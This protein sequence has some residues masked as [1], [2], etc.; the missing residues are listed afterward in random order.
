MA[1]MALF[2][3]VGGVLATNGWD[4]NSR[5]LAATTFG[6]DL[7]EMNERHG[8]TFGLYEAG[9]ITLEQYLDRAV[10]YEERSFTRQQFRDFML[11]QS[12]VFPEMIELVRALKARYKL[13]VAL[14]NNEGRELNEYR[15]RSFQLGGFVDCFVSSCY[16]GM[17]KPDEGIFRMALDVAQVAPGEVAYLDDRLL[18]VQV[19]AGLGMRG[20]HH[21]A[22]LSTVAALAGLGLTLEG[23]PNALDM[24]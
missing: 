18:F 14:V 5:E 19:A 4:R 22:Y 23:S 17:R 10:F 3:D 20:I 21:T 15:I 11:A 8:L 12:R 9:K 6:L 16:V 1:T 7:Q 13:K 24:V 2:L